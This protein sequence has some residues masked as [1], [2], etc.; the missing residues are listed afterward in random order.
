MM[1]C[2]ENGLDGVTR[3]AAA[4]TDAALG[5]DFEEAR[6][7]AG[8]VATRADALGFAG[9]AAAAAALFEYLGPPGGSPQ[10]GYTAAILNLALELEA[11]NSPLLWSR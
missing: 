3:E 1:N 10:A 2:V 11:A 4:A 9:I 8:A 7:R 6:F 5:Q